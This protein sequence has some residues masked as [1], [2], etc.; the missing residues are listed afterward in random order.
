MSK[1]KSIKF[2]KKEEKSRFK[3][4]LDSFKIVK[5][6][7]TSAYDDDNGEVKNTG[8]DPEIDRIFNQA[9]SN[10]AA[11]DRFYD[12]KP[13]NVRPAPNKQYRPSEEDLYEMRARENGDNEISNE[14]EIG[15]K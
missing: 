12:R 5:D 10:I 7:Y 11:A 4:F 13:T 6:A 8:S 15:N 3:K 2:N 14:K 9:E 1:D